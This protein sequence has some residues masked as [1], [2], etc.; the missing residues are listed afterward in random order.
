METI[1]SPLVLKAGSNA[2][3]GR[4]PKFDKNK[5][6]KI[7]CKKVLS[8]DKVT[9]IIPQN[10]D[11][12]IPC[13]E[14]NTQY[15]VQYGVKNHDDDDDDYLWL[16]STEITT[17]G[18]KIRKTEKYDTLLAELKCFRPDYR[19]CSLGVNHVNILLVGRIGAGKS[20]LIC[21]IH[22]VF[23]GT[24]NITIAPFGPSSTSF[25]Q[26]FRKIPSKFNSHIWFYDIYGMEGDNLKNV[27]EPLLMGRLREGHKKG[28]PVNGDL[29]PPSLLEQVHVVMLVVEQ[30]TL[31]QDSEVD[32]LLKLL[33]QIRG[34]GTYINLK[35]FIK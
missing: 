8:N 19:I 29:D 35:I 32:N 9:E 20:S 12:M 27:L 11:F 14:P 31:S 10:Q 30:Q 16:E 5:E 4:I 24:T 25:T 22:S 7:H 17:Y 33:N 6:Y 28:D 15:S 26:I 18:A 21:T 3:F 34:Y 23:E 1:L 13:L 2:I